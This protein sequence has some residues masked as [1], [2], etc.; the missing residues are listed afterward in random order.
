MQ[1]TRAAM[2]VVG[3]AMAAGGEGL[4]VASQHIETDQGGTSKKQEDSGTS[5]EEARGTASGTEKG[6]GSSDGAGEGGSNLG[7]K[8]VE[9]AEGDS[10]GTPRSRL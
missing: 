9:S 2:E 10:G 6:D 7:G 5:D 3:D 1:V 8:A 4:K